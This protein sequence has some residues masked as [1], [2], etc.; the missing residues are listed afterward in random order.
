MKLNLLVPCELL[1]GPLERVVLGDV[2]CTSCGGVEAWALHVLRY[3]DVYVDV[4]GDALLLVI[5]LHLN[6]EA[7]LGVRWGLD[8]YVHCEEGLHSN[9]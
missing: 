1:D 3:R 8:D 5:A 6:D 2:G 7:N 4:V 9:I